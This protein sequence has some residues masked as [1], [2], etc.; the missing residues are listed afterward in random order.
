MS[1]AMSETSSEVVTID[2]PVPRIDAMLYS[3]SQRNG[4]GVGGR[5]WRKAAPQ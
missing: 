4:N 1:T 3:G 5:L 2:P